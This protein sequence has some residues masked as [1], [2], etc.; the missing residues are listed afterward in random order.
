MHP[1]IRQHGKPL[2][3]RVAAVACAVAAVAVTG[4]G[5][6]KTDPPKVHKVAYADLGV[7]KNL[8]SYLKDTILERTDLSNTGVL[9][10]SSYG[11]VVNLRYSGDSQAPTAVREWMIKEMYRHGMGNLRIP[12]YRDMTPERVLADK[13][14]ALVIV[15]AYIPPG[16]RKGQRVDPICQALPQSNTASLAGGTLYQCELKLMGANPL[17]PAGAV[18]KFV[19]ARGPLFINPAYAL[20]TPSVSEG[21]ARSGAR[22]ASVLG[23]G[24]VITDRPVQL[25]LRTPQWSISRAIEQVVNT[26]F[27]Q[28]ADKPRQD[29]RGQCVAEAQD[30]GYLNLYVPMSYKG[31]WEHF[32][33]VVTH[34]YINLNPAVAAVKA[35]E[36]AE[37]AKKPGA[38]LEDI[39]YALEGIG[40]AS[41]PY[42]TP[43][44]S[45]PSPDVRFAAARAGMFLGDTG[46]EDAMIRIA[47][48]VGHPF[49]LNAIV[50]L[51][52][53][54]NN[55]EIN[56]AMA[57]CLDSDESLIRINA[58]KVLAA[59]NDRTRISSIPVNESFILDV[60]DT[61]GAPLIYANRVGEPRLAVFGK[62]TSIHQPVTFTA[63]DAQLS[64]ATSAQRPNL[65]S[66]FYRGDE[67]PEP[68][69][70]LSRP[71]VAE[72]AARLGG[73]GDEKLRFSYGDIVGMLQSM[74][75]SGKVSSPFVLQ[76]V[77]LVDE[78]LLDTPDGTGGGGGGRP[79]GEPTVPVPPARAAAGTVDVPPAV[80]VNA[81]P[82]TGNGVSSGRAN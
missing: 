24:Y 54:P 75:D 58:Y 25:R 76:D 74:S 3:R 16:A 28:V 61:P 29:G 1:W 77:P 46:S 20:Q 11:L 21:I 45:H 14:A 4:S 50:A 19:E 60:V 38:L 68:V 37:E 69:N 31:N 34:L 42:I 39:S 44:L 57:T 30:E 8:P 67:L 27:Q 70:T 17:N 47:Q 7:K 73:S 6:S 18:N 9:A 72:L 5:C 33:G 43:L 81:A 80:G 22:T 53:V 63:F 51:G 26:R 32:M 23:G 40:A 62:Q 2:F 36:L 59:N 66:I 10:V 48:Q 12:G 64:I 78:S 65:L 13:R 35:Q 52:E 82:P 55:A 79:V 15:G 49:R 41:I 56:R 71:N